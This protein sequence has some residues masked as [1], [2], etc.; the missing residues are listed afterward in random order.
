MSENEDD[1]TGCGGYERQN[2]LHKSR[3]PRHNV[4]FTDDMNESLHNCYTRT[5]NN[6]K[7][8]SSHDYEKHR[9]NDRFH[10]YESANKCRDY[11]SGVGLINIF[12]N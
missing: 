4:L 3:K 12:F 2:R 6:I 9:N 7:E 8:V 11:E 5:N 1:S 10:A